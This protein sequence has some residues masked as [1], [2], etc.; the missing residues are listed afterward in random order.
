MNFRTSFLSSGTYADLRVKMGRKARV[1]TEGV[2]AR[3][4]KKKRVRFLSTKSD[5]VARIYRYR[6]S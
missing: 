1:E 6:T 3:V 2:R 4:P 5:T